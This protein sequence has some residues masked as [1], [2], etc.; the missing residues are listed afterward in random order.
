MIRGKASLVATG[1][2][3]LEPHLLLAVGRIEHL[4]AQVETV[5]EPAV[6][7]DRVEGQRPALPLDRV[8]DLEEVTGP[9]AGDASQELRPESLVP[10]PAEPILPPPGG[11]VAGER[12][13]APEA[14]AP[15]REDGVVFRADQRDLGERLR[16]R[17]DVA[18]ELR[19]AARFE[20]AEGV[21]DQVM[22][23]W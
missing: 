8:G 15:L 3:L 2:D 16:G 22:R 6:A 20:A 5:D 10:R 7:V 14:V 23:R 13:G 9:A 18:V 12:G 17:H 21:D 19:E 4:T 1:G 11:T